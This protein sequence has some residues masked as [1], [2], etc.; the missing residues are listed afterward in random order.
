[1]AGTPWAGGSGG[2][3]STT[4]GPPAP[5]SRSW[6][7]RPISGTIGSEGVGLY[8]PLSPGS[9]SVHIAVRARG[10]LDALA[11]RLRAVASEVDPTLRVYDL[12]PLDKVG[13]NLW[14]ESQYLSRLLIV[15]SGIALLLSLTAIYSVMA[16]TVAQRT[17][18]IGLRMAL[19]AD[20]GR[21]VAAVVRR[22]L[23][24]I[25]LGIVMGGALVALAFWGMF[26]SAPTLREAGLIA[27][28][29]VLMLGICL[30]ACVVPTRRA[31]RLEP[32]RVLRGDG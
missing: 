20:R 2:R 4:Y 19:G 12:M 17:R 26:E 7:W 27:A 1:M 18:E 10:D 21:I 23:V 28:Y 29:A 3:L 22:P 14:L 30:L 25:G 13:A 8:R 11:A 5:G 9:P 32:S 15:L 31:L 6:A 16:F 24:Q